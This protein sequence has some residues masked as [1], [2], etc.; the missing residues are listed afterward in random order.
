MADDRCRAVT[1][2]R[3]KSEHH[4]A[5]CRVK[6]AGSIRPATAGQMLTESVTENKPPVLWKQSAGKGEKAR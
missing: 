3:G 4:T 6:D 2:G 5:A 1:R